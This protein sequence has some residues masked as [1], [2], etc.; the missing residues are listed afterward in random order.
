MKGFTLIESLVVVFIILVLTLVTLPNYR[1]G[2]K[3]ARSLNITSEEDVDR[4]LHA[5]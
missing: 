4:I 2:E 5:R 3:T 1:R